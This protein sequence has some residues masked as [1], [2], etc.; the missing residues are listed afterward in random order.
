MQP[1]EQSR[2]LPED[3]I[4]TYLAGALKSKGDTSDDYFKFDRAFVNLS[5]DVIR[6][7]AQESAFG[8]PI[9]AGSSYKVNM[10]GGKIVATSVG[11]N[12][13]RMPIHPLLMEY[14]GFIF[15]SLWDAMQREKDAMDKMQSVSVE[16]GQFVF[17]T[18]PHA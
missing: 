17:T 10:S 16:P 12:I 18:K 11:G 13:G 14:S 9:Y 2:Q 1:T 4:N 5:K 15:Q 7:T 8:Y 6:I 3:M